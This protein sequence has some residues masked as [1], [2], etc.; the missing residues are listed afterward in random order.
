MVAKM[1]D[2]LAAINQKLSSYKKAADVEKYEEFAQVLAK[3]IQSS[4]RLKMT[5][6]AERL[7]L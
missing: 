1:E 3:S 5:Y 2:A 6:L 7:R 4:K